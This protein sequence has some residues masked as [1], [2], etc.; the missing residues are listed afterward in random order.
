MILAWLK[1]NLWRALAGA[2]ALW[3]AAL[4]IEMHGL[5]VLGG[6]IRAGLAACRA[7]LAAIQRAQAEAQ[8]AQAAVNAAEERRSAANARRSETDH[9]IDLARALAAGSAYAGSHRCP[10]GGLRPEGDRSAASQAPAA[11]AGGS[12]GLPAKLPA[13][14]FVAVSRADVQACTA[15]VTYA[16]AAHNWAQTLPREDERAPER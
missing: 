10:A 3:C 11:A 12:A 9:D 4:L 2:L 7:D 5:P 14:P 13:D 15:A 8:Q 16:V 6:G 1:T